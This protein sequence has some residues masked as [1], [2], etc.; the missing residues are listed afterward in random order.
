MPQEAI[1]AFLQKTDFICSCLKLNVSL[2]FSSV[3]A[4]VGWHELDLNKAW[5]QGLRVEA[6]QLASHGHCW[7]L[8][9]LCLPSRRRT[10]RAGMA[11]TITEQAG[12]ILL[13]GQNWTR[14]MKPN[15][16][17]ESPL[18]LKGIHTC[19][20][21]Y[22]CVGAH[23]QMEYVCVSRTCVHSWKSNQS[24]FFPRG[25]SKYEQMSLAESSEKWKMH[26]AQSQ[27]RGHQP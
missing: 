19:M 12:P 24:M 20:F 6:P 18:A 16:V 7:A 15:D 1:P 5:R 10:L 26:W 22:A 13:L 21:M 2:N 17:T 3:W 27:V 8:G 11:L 23:T 25:I 4:T 9:A 14:K